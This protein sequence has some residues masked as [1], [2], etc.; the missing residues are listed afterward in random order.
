MKIIQ[1]NKLLYKKL[2]LIFCLIMTLMVIS[3]HWLMSFSRFIFLVVFIFFLSCAV[4]C[5]LLAESKEGK[6]ISLDDDGILIHG[7]YQSQLISWS[8]IDRFEEKN[9]KFGMNV[10]YIYL[11]NEHKFII[12]STLLS[13]SKEELLI[14]LQDMHKTYGAIDHEKM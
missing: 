1:I 11:K 4:V 6:G 13:V 10:I 9:F 7:I 12:I 2:C 5:R 14:D 3:S 8:D